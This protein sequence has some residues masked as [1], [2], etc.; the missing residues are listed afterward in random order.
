M[1]EP[2]D[3]VSLFLPNGVLD[4]QD[5][6]NIIK[7]MPQD[8]DFRTFNISFTGIADGRLDLPMKAIDFKPLLIMGVVTL[9]QN[10]SA[11]AGVELSFQVFPRSFVSIILGSK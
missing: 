6:T 5:S 1:Q 8:D 10:D 2:L 11:L 3:E 7:I 9:A 4:L